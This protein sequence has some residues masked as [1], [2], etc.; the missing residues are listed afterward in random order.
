MKYTIVLAAVAS[1]VAAQDLGTIPS[2]AVPCLT[3]AFI[4]NGC[5]ATDIKCACGNFSKI[6]ADAAG[7]IIGKCGISDA[8]N[9]VL[10]AAEAL[11]KGN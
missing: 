4:K 9:K 3:D 5:G 10:P 8:I 7:C 2:C 6:K 11:C 1:L